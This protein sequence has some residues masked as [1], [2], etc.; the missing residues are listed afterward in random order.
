MRSDCRKMHHFTFR[1]G[2][3]SRGGTPNP[4]WGGTQG[5]TVAYSGPLGIFTKKHHDNDS[6]KIHK[7]IQWKNAFR[8]QKKA[9]FCI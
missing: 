3:F 2:K 1:F 4:L 7:K 8:M 9:P 5:A 6:S